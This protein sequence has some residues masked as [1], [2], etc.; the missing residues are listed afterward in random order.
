MPKVKMRVSMAGDRHVRNPGDVIE[1]S[2]K[3]AKSLIDAGFAEAVEEPKKDGEG[4]GKGGKGDEKPLTAMRRAP[5]NAM[6][7]PGG[8][9]P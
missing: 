1:V 2:A 9:R 4:E 3:E 8:G 7:P 6:R 5:E